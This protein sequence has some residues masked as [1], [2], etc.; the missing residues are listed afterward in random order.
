MG[1]KAA[2]GG[3]HKHTVRIIPLTGG[4]AVFRGW[5]LV[6]LA[7]DTWSSAKSVAYYCTRHLDCQIQR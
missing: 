1:L 5:P 7:S 6:D 2:M 4:V 3:K